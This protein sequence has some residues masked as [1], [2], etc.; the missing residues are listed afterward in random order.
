[1]SDL[2]EKDEIEGLLK[3]LPEWD[4]EEKAICRVVEFEDYMDGV[5]LLNG[6]ADI[7]EEANHHPDM[8]IKWGQLTIRLTTHDMGG[9]TDA[10][11]DLAGRI[12]NLID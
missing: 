3:K 6:V 11:F 5:D 12:D 2:V 10:D 9:L 7:A 8:E 1:M 4:L